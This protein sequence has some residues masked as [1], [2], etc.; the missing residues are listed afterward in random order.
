MHTDNSPPLMRVLGSSGKSQI[1]EKNEQS[2][3]STIRIVSIVL[4]KSNHKEK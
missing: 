2:Q 1:I 4:Q 3:V